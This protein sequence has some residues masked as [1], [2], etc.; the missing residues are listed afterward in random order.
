M[1]EFAKDWEKIAQTEEA[2][3]A[4][5][6][7][8]YQNEEWFNL[9]G[10]L[11]ASKLLEIVAQYYGEKCAELRFL[12]IGCGTGRETR[13]FADCF[14]EVLAVDV[15]ETMIRKAIKRISNGN[16]GLYVVKP[17]ILRVSDGYLE[18]FNDE[19]IDIVY[20]FIVFQH[21]EREVVESYFKEAQ[22][23]LKSGGLFIFQLHTGPEHIEPSD[24]T[25]YSFWTL[26][27]IREN[28]R[29]ME[30]IRLTETGERMDLFIF[31]KR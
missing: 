27:E 31:K 24:F 15:S 30:E 10:I 16:V 7:G 13:Y 5:A 8:N 6:S 14:G 2:H 19:S 26:K 18:V 21:C 9:S 29:D 1:S 25:S 12:E 20:S 3:K 22:R 17:G 11:S 28:L 4:I 23:V